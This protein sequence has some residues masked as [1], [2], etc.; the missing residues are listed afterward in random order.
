MVELGVPHRN[1]TFCLETPTEG[2]TRSPGLSFR[3]AMSEQLNLL[4]AETGK[5]LPD[6]ARHDV[7]SLLK[8]VCKAAAT[9]VLDV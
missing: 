9:Q 6:R 1:N 3:R 7:E 2:R 5:Y 4:R 8:E